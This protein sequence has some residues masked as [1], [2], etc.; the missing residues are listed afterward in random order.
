M[1]IGI[2]NSIRSDWS[3]SFPIVTLSNQGGLLAQVWSDDSYRFIDKINCPVKSVYAHLSY[4]SSRRN[5]PL[6]NRL[7][8]VYVC[9]S[10]AFGVA[11]ISLMSIPVKEEKEEL[12]ASD[13][14]P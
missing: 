14:T 7:F 13:S 3:K 1:R 6:I 11:F 2:P 4:I 5:E 12:P 10:L 8:P 9:A